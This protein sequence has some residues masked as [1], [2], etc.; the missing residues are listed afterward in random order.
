MRWAVTVAV[1]GLAVQGQAPP[2]VYFVRFTPKIFGMQLPA[3]SGNP[4]SHCY[5]FVRLGTPPY[6]AEVAC[7]IG[8]VFTGRL[9]TAPAG[10]GFDGGFAAPGGGFIRWAVCD[11]AAPP[12]CVPTTL[13]PAGLADPM[14]FTLGAQLGDGSPAQTVSGYY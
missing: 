12:V 6:D 2:P 1:L 5:A 11:P 10:Q 14:Y 4:E 3:S 7:Y 8:G 13:P 9:D